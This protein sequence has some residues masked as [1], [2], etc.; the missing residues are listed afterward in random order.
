VFIVN[1]R[2]RQMLFAAV[3]QID[4]LS[5]ETLP[6]IKVEILLNKLSENCGI[7]NRTAVNSVLVKVI[8]III[9]IMTMWRID[10]LLS[11]SLETSK[12]SQP[13]LYNKRIKKL[14]FLSNGW[15]NTLLRKRTRPQQ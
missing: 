8:I 5:I 11:K 14:M 4:G 2:N 12:R 6:A 9:I 15:V 13:L 10:S 7:H 3:T 1:Y